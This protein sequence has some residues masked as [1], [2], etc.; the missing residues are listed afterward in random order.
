MHDQPRFEPLEKNPLFADGRSVRPQVPG[1]IARGQLREDVHMFVGR[2][3]KKK[4][5]ELLFPVTETELEQ[6]L[7][8]IAGET[9]ADTFPLPITGEIVQHGRERFEVF[10]S[11]CHGRLGEA[12]GIVVQRGFRPPPSYH[13]D[14]LREAPVGHFFDVIT[15]GIGAMEDFSDRVPVR[16]RWAIASYI[17]VLQ[18]SRHAIL[19]NLPPRTQEEFRD[20]VSSRP[21]VPEMEPA[22]PTP[23][24]RVDLAEEL[25]RLRA[26]E[27]A[28]MA[29]YG[30]VEREKGVV[31][32]PVA[33]AAEILLERGFS[34]R[35]ETVA[36]GRQ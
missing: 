12:N 21:A 34:V 23:R 22:P 32:I 17:R 3:P 35:P 28:R 33:R 36:G 30:W 29:G 31:F 16:D 27:E 8:R 1:T 9:L 20:F 26:I 15:R 11:P 19:A 25:A 4:T 18:F 7:A 6:A 14:R 5:D 24:L 10:C 2:S 13:I